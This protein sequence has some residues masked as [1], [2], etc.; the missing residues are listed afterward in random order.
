MRFTKISNKLKLLSKFSPILIQFPHSPIWLHQHNCLIN[1][2]VHYSIIICKYFNNNNNNYTLQH[3]KVITRR[4]SKHHLKFDNRTLCRHIQNIC[5]TM[6][7]AKL[8]LHYMQFTLM[9]SKL[10][11][12][13]HYF[14]ILFLMIQLSRACTLSL[15]LFLEN[16]FFTMELCSC[17][18]GHNSEC[19]WKVQWFFCKYL[20]CSLMSSD[21]FVSLNDLLIKFA[22]F[23]VKWRKIPVKFVQLVVCD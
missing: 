1:K 12:L 6:N 11:A 18:T 9:T 17:N 10:S 15:N 16:F 21:I 7:I 4:K 22:Q 5:V 2:F 8:L 3:T 23:L 20:Y 13:L 19:T 14:E